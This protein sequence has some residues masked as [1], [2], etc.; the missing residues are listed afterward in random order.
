MSEIGIKMHLLDKKQTDTDSA[1]PL[2]GEDIICFAGEDWWYHNPHSNLHIMKA[3]SKANRVL[4]VNSIGV[5]MPDFKKDP[6]FAWKRITGKLKSLLRYFRKGAH[7]IY[8]LTPIAIPLIGGLEP[9]LQV[10]NK[11]LLVLQLKVLL[12]F[13]HF[14]HPVLWVCA[15]TF[16]DIALALKREAKCLLYYCV[17]NISYYSGSINRF[18]LG[19][20]IDLL[21]NA[22]LALF[23][24]HRLIA[25]KCEYS[26]RIRHIGHG[27]DYE[28]F[29]K[30]QHSN[31]PVPDDMKQIPGPIV[32]YLGALRGLDF[33][34]VQFLA[35]KN[36]DLSFVFIGEVLEEMSPIASLRN[37]YFLGQKPYA[38]LPDYMN[39]VSCFGIFYQRDGIFNNY[40]NPKKLLECLATGK[41]VVSVPILEM[42]YFKD[43]VLVAQDYEHFHHLIRGA[44]E[45]DSPL[46]KERR[47]EYAKDHTWDKIGREVA[48][49]I[50]QLI[51]KN[52]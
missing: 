10:I 6:I 39:R 7:N 48:D 37:V 30:A 51:R 33:A 29:A 9:T 2:F 32:A 26:E 43:L 8:V 13:L 19:L 49:Q 1:L 11:F 22:D 40:R 5:R 27:V 31:L 3:L 17:D 52:V 38:L 4:F 12:S 47:I 23:V 50:A 15:P 18:V 44:I 34:L 35:E 36:P 16:K 25:E 20:E 21:K 24:N 42:E 46:I 45:N 14:E 28:H 41:P